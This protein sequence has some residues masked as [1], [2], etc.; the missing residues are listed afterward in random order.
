M[1]F[2]VFIVVWVI[3][4]ATLWK[5]F[6]PYVLELISAY[7]VTQTENS[8]E[9]KRAS[10]DEPRATPTPFIRQMPTPTPMPIQVGPI[11]KSPPVIV[12]GP[13]GKRSQFTVYVFTQEY[14][15]RKGEIIV[16]F[17]GKD[18]PESTMVAY[19]SEIH[20]DMRTTDAL[21]C[22]GTA[23]YDVEDNEA[24]EEDRALMRGLQLIIWMRRT[25]A[26]VVESPQLYALNLGHYKEGKDKNEQRLIIIFGV[27]RI[28]P[29]ADIEALLS[30][31][32]SEALKAK[33]KEKDFPFKL[34]S[35]SKFELIKRS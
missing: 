11:R 20:G 32:N 19:L 5:I 33:L 18:I 6:S 9:K 24:G 26:H 15:W 8:D 29:D 4:G 3:T 13:D 25:L 17:N 35:Y 7:F 16:A 22:V 31:Q 27:K 14:H 2:I 34:E 30:A 10:T 28:D 1:A 23:S 21:V 12:E